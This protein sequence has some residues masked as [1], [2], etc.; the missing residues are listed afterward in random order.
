MFLENSPKIL[1]KAGEMSKILSTE[2]GPGNAVRALESL[3]AETII[4]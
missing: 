4:T 1:K 3:H 2:D